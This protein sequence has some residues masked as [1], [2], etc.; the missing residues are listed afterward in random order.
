[1]LIW[2]TL[3]QFG[4]SDFDRIPTLQRRFAI[5]LMCSADTAEEQSDASGR[6]VQDCRLSLRER[7]AAFAEQKATL[8][9]VRV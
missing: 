1:L 3:P 7:I 2:T 4:L 6:L 9:G 5:G 8:D